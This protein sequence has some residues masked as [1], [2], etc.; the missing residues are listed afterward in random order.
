MA[1]C[2]RSVLSDRPGRAL[3]A[4]RVNALA[5][6]FDVHVGYSLDSLKGGY[7]GDHTGFLV[8]SLL[9][10]ILGGQTIA[11][12]GHGSLWFCGFGD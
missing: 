5:A 9:R 3:C 6:N 12:L 7:V 11:H 10:R 1:G 8:W 2:A 4:A